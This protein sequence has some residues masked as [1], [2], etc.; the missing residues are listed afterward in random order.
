MKTKLLKTLNKFNDKESG[1]F[2][3][4]ALLGFLYF[5]ASLIVRA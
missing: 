2:E 5:I 3:A 1:L 4:V